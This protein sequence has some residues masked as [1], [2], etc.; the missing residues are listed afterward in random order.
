LQE[1][2]RGITQDSCGSVKK[3]WGILLFE[4][5]SC[6]GHEQQKGNRL[7]RKTTERLKRAFIGESV[8]DNSTP[9]FSKQGRRNKFFKIAKTFKTAVKIKPVH[10]RFTN[11]GKIMRADDN[12]FMPVSASKSRTFIGGIYPVPRTKETESKP[13][14]ADSLAFPRETKKVCVGIREDDSKDP[15]L[16]EDRE[17]YPDIF[18][19]GHCGYTCKNERPESC[20]ICK[21][22]CNAFFR[23]E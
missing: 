17:E 11:S 15:E 21:A 3:E 23:V 5:V 18:I 13:P 7:M 16:R 19:C 12:H 4:Y 22:R 10:S 9:V 1:I 20:P 6:G 2:C 8:T 14:S